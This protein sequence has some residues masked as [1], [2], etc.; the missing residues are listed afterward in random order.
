MHSV[1]DRDRD[2]FLERGEKRCVIVR[3]MTVQKRS[4]CIDAKGGQDRRSCTCHRINTVSEQLFASRVV[5]LPVR[6]LH[7]TPL[8]TLAD[9]CLHKHIAAVLYLR[10]EQSKDRC[11]VK[12]H[13][14]GPL[15]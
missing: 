6:L 5:D 2:T 4:R 14:A 15:S 12:T 1:R 7:N 8:L 11:S 9:S 3:A 10:L 13:L